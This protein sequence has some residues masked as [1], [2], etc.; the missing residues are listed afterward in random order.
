[1]QIL[2]IVATVLVSQA[3]AVPLA[4]P[5][6]GSGSGALE[7]REPKNM[8]APWALRKY[9]EQPPKYHY[10]VKEGNAKRSVETDEDAGDIEARSPKNKYL[11]FLK[12]INPLGGSEGKQQNKKQTGDGPLIRGDM[13]REMGPLFNN[14][15]RSVETTDEDA[16]EIGARDVTAAVLETREPKKKALD[17]LKGYN[18][19]GSSG[20]KPKQSTDGPLIR[21]DMAREM[22]PL[23]N[24]D[25]R[26]VETSDE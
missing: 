9:R 10:P 18:P 1:M 14:D 16:A 4:L 26:S 25:K 22:G 23:F 19:L 20:G 24:N 17:F 13:A 11:N 2:P 12:A 3:A 6:S 7:A 8:N 5:Q 21:G 15:K